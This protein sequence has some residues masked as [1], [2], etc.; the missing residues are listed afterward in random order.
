MPRILLVGHLFQF[1]VMET[2]IAK[3]NS[4]KW[5]VLYAMEIYLGRCVSKY[6]WILL[7]Q[8]S[9]VK[10]KYGGETENSFFSWSKQLTQQPTYL[11]PDFTLNKYL[12]FTSPKT[13]TTWIHSATIG[14]NTVHTE[15]TIIATHLWK[16]WDPR[17]P[18]SNPI[19]LSCVSNCL[20]IFINHVEYCAYCDFP[21]KVAHHPSINQDSK[22][23]TPIMIEL[24]TTTFLIDLNSFST[25]WWTLEFAKSNMRQSLW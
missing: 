7:L 18:A 17:Y 8:S 14:G 21:Q 16:E 25:F 11:S 12:S 13:H 3:Q 23:N 24:D 19:P 10:S 5:F 22:T 15:A 2:I 1:F 20:T 4:I 6:W 9:S